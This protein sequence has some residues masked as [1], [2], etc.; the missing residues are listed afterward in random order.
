MLGKLTRW[1]RLLG[2]DCAY[3]RDIED[4]KLLEIARTDERILITR[5]QSLV[6]KAQKMNL[7]VQHIIGTTLFEKLEEVVRRWNLRIDII[8]DNSRCSA[9]NGTVKRVTKICVKGRVPEG[10]LKHHKKFWE[11]TECG[12]IYWKGAHWEHIKHIEGMLKLT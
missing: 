2:N 9:C 5:D 4:D 10:T 6:Q 7:Q 3:F 11:C 1:L 8:P 12:K